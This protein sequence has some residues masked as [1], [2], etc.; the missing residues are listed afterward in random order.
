MHGGCLPRKPLFV[1][2]L[3]KKRQDER[4]VEEPGKGVL[5]ARKNALRARN[6]GRQERRKVRLSH[7]KEHKD[8]EGENGERPQKV[9]DA[10][11]ACKRL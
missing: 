5:R 7:G 1:L 9:E 11:E 3:I 10:P 2:Y 8:G 6:A 4:P